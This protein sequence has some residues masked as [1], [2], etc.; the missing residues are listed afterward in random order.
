MQYA[1]FMHRENIMSLVHSLIISKVDY[2]NSLFVGLPNVTLKKIQSV[3]NRAARLLCH[4]PLRVSITASLIDLHWLPIKARI[5]Y[6]ICLITFK[7]L[8]FHQPK[9]ICDLLIPLAGE[10]DVV[11]RSSGDPF[12]LWEPRAPGERIFADRSFSYV[13]PRIYNRLP[14]VI[15]Q[16][17]TLA[18]F[19]KHLKTHLFNLSYDFANHTVSEMHRV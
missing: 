18:C 1:D 3:M 2:C 17:E 4:L 12:R 15:K 13:A 5:E 19:K 8:K 9:Y 16:L 14:V 11:L 7:A 10:R 6:K